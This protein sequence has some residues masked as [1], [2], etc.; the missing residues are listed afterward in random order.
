MS[1]SQNLAQEL[2]QATC[3]CLDQCMTKIRHCLGQLSQR[4]VWWRPAED[5]NAIGNL[6]LHLSGNVRQW[7][8]AGVSGSED[9]RDR[10]QEFA[11]REAIAKQELLAGLQATIDEAKQVLC[12]L[13]EAELLAPRRIQGFD[14]S[15]VGAIFDS[16]PHFK[17]HTQEIVCL[18]RM[19]LGEKYQYHW[20]PKTPEQG[21]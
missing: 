2:V 13:G 1:P 8:V 9:T 16:V 15:A 7:L 19:Q 18:T 12:S 14:L 17:G 11:Q 20:E 4:Q 5:M 6:L 3:T 10:P 21:A